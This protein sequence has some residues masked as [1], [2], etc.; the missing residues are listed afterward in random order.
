MIEDMESGG[1]VDKNLASG[2]EIAF[3]EWLVEITLLLLACERYG[4]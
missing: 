2:F 4:L 3:G 1:C